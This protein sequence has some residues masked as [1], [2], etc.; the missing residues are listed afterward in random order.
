MITTKKITGLIALFVWF[1]ASLS[2]A[3]NSGH[4]QPW[5]NNKGRHP[6]RPVYIGEISVLPGNI[7]NLEDKQE[8]SKIHFAMNKLHIVTR[9]EVI[10]RQLLFKSGDVFDQNKL[11]ESERLLRKNHYIKDAEIIPQ[12]VCKGRVNIIVRTTDNWTLTPGVSFG[13]SGGSNKSGAEIQEHNLLGMGKSLALSY[14]T[15]SQRDSYKFDYSDNQFLNTRKE[16]GIYLESNSDGHTYGFALASPFYAIDT[17]DSWYINWQDSAKETS[18]YQNGAA[19]KD[20]AENREILDLGYAWS[21]SADAQHSSRY[22]A[23]WQY[24]QRDIE[25]ISDAADNSQITASYP[26][27]GYEYLEN[28]YAELENFNTM[29]RIEDVNFGRQF[30]IRAGF[31]TKALGSDSNQIKLSTELSESFFADPQHLATLNLSTTSYFGDGELSGSEVQL[32]GRYQHFL[33]RKNALNLKATLRAADNFA[34]NEQYQLG[35]LEDM[36]GYSE[37]FQAGNKSAVLNLEYRHFFDKSPYQL[38]KFA[39]VGFADIGT[40]WDNHNDPEIVTDVGVGLRIVPTRS[41][42]SRV[43]HVDLAFPLDGKDKA[44]GVQLSIGTKTTF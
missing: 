11:D 13:R 10:E 18:F 24:D 26:W 32:S 9:P 7:F 40:A 29:G 28:A 37:G 21:E 15:D 20:Y 12:R 6:E 27:V 39:A 44:D 2:A 22:S 3:G 34:L 38:F 23:G 17:P 43:I 19:T 4:C 30:R 33:D 14:K 16:L 5:Q 41:S 35:G 8:D 36:R 42:S 25:N 31:L 1:P